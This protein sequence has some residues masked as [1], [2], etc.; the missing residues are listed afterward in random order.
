MSSREVA[1]DT[2]RDKDTVATLSH[3]L[4]PEGRGPAGRSEEQ[5]VGAEAVPRAPGR[6]ASQTP[7]APVLSG[8]RAAAD[9]SSRSRGSRTPRRPAVLL[10]NHV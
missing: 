10:G 2:G 9:G 5:Q 4:S 8:D 1:R 6:R 7:R 3:P